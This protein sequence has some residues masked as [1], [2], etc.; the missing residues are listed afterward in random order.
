MRFVRLVKFA[1]LV[2]LIGAIGFGLYAFGRRRPQ[3]V[4]WTPLDLGQ[5]I[6][7]FTA[8]KLAGLTADAPRCRALLDAAGVR[9]TRLP[10]RI[11]P[12]GCGYADGVAFTGGGARTIALSPAR[13]GTSCAIAASLAVW[14][15]EVV[16]PAAL[17]RFGRPVTRDRS[18]RQLQLP[19]P[20]WP[21]DRRL[22]RAFHRRRDR[23]RRLPPRRRH[24]HHRG[25][26]LG[27]R[28]REGRLPPRCPR[29]RVPAVR[30]HAVARL[31][32][33]PRRSPPSRS[34]GARARSAGAASARAARAAGRFDKPPP[35][36][37]PAPNEP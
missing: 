23:H 2:A 16:Q 5:P 27:G 22:E 20:L 30:H 25:A 3:D 29:R 9:F 12:G 26:R 13:L 11:G 24:P 10:P 34:G 6:G 18:F 37:D 8:R 32:R 31:Q 4:P 15:W 19:S 14:E 35:M 28:G 33:R 7:A 1:L 17:R 36:C 21:R